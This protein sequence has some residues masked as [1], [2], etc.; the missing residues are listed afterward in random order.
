[1]PGSVGLNYGVVRLGSSEVPSVNAIS[2]PSA[3]NCSAGGEYTDRAGHG[4][5]FVVDDVGGHWQSAIEVPESA[6]LNAGG[7]AEINSVSCASAGNC[8][9]GGDFATSSGGLEAMVVDEVGGVWAPAIEVP[10]TEVLN[11]YGDASVVSMSCTSPG[12]CSAGGFYTDRD[13]SQAFV[14]DEVAGIW[15]M[16]QEIPGILNTGGNAQVRSLSCA[17][18]GDCS[19]G[20]YY[21]TGRS[22]FGAFVVNETNG[23]WSRA[24]AVPNSAHLDTGH[25]AGLDLVSCSGI[26]ICSAVG[27]YLTV[28]DGRSVEQPFVV[29]ES[30]GVWG[31]AASMLLPY[32]L[33]A[34]G[35]VD[36]TA[37][38]C[39]IPGK[40][41]VGGDYWNKNDNWH[42]FAES[43]V[44]GT[45]REAAEIPGTGPLNAGN[46]AQ[47]NSVSCGAGGYCAA[48]GYVTTARRTQQ[49]FVV[50]ETQNVWH[51]AQILP[52]SQRLN[53]GGAAEVG[54][55]S[56]TPSGFCAAGGDYTARGGSQQLFVAA[57]QP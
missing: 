10:A 1:M 29:T 4:Q 54:A 3:N 17:A 19:A 32:R 43:Q 18:P 7:H 57:F 27:D 36:A 47:V 22:G 41:T 34:A 12:Y 48:A 38:S 20:G 16:A 56:C 55:V 44:N 5:A 14:V 24:E 35:R 52:N 25:L 28:T 51:A 15:G 53:M 8:A 23:V 9:A 37:L 39:A 30:D 33:I 31:P 13:G 26:G 42:V 11:S 49:A 46:N 6:A 40:C 45:W 2:C 21:A 50:L